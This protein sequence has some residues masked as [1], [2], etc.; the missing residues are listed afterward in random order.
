MKIPEEKQAGREDRK[1]VT[2][3][4]QFWFI[5]LKYFIPPT[6][7]RRSSKGKSQGKI[8]IKLTVLD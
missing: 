5:L 7:P 4:V 1:D 6:M 3:E 2:E 8:K